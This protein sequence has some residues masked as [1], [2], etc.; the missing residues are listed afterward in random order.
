LFLERQHSQ[1]NTNSLRC[2]VAKRRG[3]PVRQEPLDKAEYVCLYPDLASR[4][5]AKRS[6][7]DYDC[8]HKRLP[9]LWRAYWV[10]S[11]TPHTCSLTT[12]NALNWR[13]T[14]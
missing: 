5:V 4:E 13:A 14:S 6:G 11:G 1:R 8:V 9:E 12:R 7:L 2:S 3:A 10:S